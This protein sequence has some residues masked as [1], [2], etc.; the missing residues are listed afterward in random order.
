MGKLLGSQHAGWFCLGVFATGLK[1]VSLTHPAKN[2]TSEH[3][4]HALQQ[5]S[6]PLRRP[7]SETVFQAERRWAL[8][9]AQSGGKPA[10]QRVPCRAGIGMLPL[11]RIMPSFDIQGK[12]QSASIKALR[13][14][15]LHVVRQSLN[16]CGL[17]SVCCSVC[18]S[19]L[20]I[21]LADAP[22][23]P[24][25][26]TASPGM[27]NVDNVSFRWTGCAL[28]QAQHLSCLLLSTRS[29][30][31]SSSHC[32]ISGTPPAPTAVH[33]AALQSTNLVHPRPHPRMHAHHPYTVTPP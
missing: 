17:L 31:H 10:D 27:A 12:G 3:H 23:L 28:G 5:P 2:I 29:P 30:A 26:S 19:V 4:F 14:R 15:N 1:T 16:R 33:A 11:V 8:H 6:E 24:L 7:P 25:A 22:D 18:A 20:T 13:T 21:A 9:A 32:H